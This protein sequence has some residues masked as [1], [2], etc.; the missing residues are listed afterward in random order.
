VLGMD[1]TRDPK[2]GDEDTPC[3]DNKVED[4]AITQA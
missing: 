4:F 2:P 3:A 1:P